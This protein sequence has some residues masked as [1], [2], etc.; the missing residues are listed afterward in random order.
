MNSTTLRRFGLIT[1]GVSL[2]V[3]SLL[4]QGIPVQS[5]L[6]RTSCGGCHRVDSAQRMS[7]ISY[8]RKT[9][10][11]WEDTVRRMGRLY[12]VSL[13]VPEAREIIRYLA[14]NQGLT[15]S[16]LEKISYVLEGRQIVEQVPNEAVKE[17]CT[18]CHTYG[19]IAAQRRTREEWGKLRDFHLA[20]FPLL[21]SIE[22][23]H[24]QIMEWP[25]IADLALGYLADQFPLETQEW[26]S[27]HPYNAPRESS[28]TI[29][30]HQ[31]GE[32]DYVGRL[33]MKVGA[34]GKYRTEAT[35]QFAD[36][37]KGTRSGEGIW[38]AG[39]AWRGSARDQ[40]QRRFREVY[41]LSADHH[42]FHGRRFLT[43]RSEVGGEEVG[44]SVEGPTKVLAVFPKA[45]KIP[46]LTSEVT[47]AGINLPTNLSLGD[48]DL[49]AGIKV[50]SIL[51]VASDRIVAR[52]SVSPQ[53]TLGRHDV[54]FHEVVGR[55]LLGLYDRIDYLQ[56]VPVRGMARLGG[57][58]V[59]KQCQQFE[60]VAF[61]K[62]PDGVEA[63]D[64][65]VE[66]GSVKASWH[67]EEYYSS[68]SDDDKDFVGTIDESGLFTPAIEAPNSKRTNTLNNAG[69]VWAV[70]E[71]LPDGQSTTLKSKAYLLV[72]F[73][74]YVKRMIP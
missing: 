33:T 1:Y 50:E 42:I 20:S 9:P 31:P 11:G 27:E 23:F 66:I 62:G 16:E 3:G 72:A 71:Y 51:P 64:D 36:G 22:E 68:Y 13:S 28:W 5:E 10:E 34:D 2:S 43:D 53:A 7:R 14:D 24:G 29:V 57:A 73:P 58:N 45:L 15:G 30:G 26:S 55:G 46:T 32:G 4:G 74:L 41:H 6:V 60:A 25:K 67:L 61:N 65:D 19:K 59:P 37:R 52:V 8:Q 56:V 18:V 44:Y 40:H 39:Y 69:D 54:R 47:I 63:T 35:V 38:Y 70:A 49:G 17:H 48:L 12:G 21:G